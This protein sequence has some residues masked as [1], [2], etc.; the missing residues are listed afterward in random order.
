MNRLR[1]FARAY[2]PP[3]LE[4]KILEGMSGGSESAVSELLCMLS[5]D[6]ITLAVHMYLQCIVTS[7]KHLA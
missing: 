4:C 7:S 5:Y 3:G 6:T 2:F 1:A